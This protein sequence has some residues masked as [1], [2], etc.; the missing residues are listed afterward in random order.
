MSASQGPWLNRFV[1]HD[2]MT[3][4]GPAAAKFYSELLGWTIVERP[5]GPFIYRMIMAGPGPIGGIVEEKEIPHA[6]WMPYISVADVDA[7]ASKGASLGGS[8]CVPPSDI[9]QTGRFAVVGDPQGAYFSLYKGLPGSEGFDPDLPVVGRVCWNE[10]LTTDDAQALQY[11]S[12]MFGWTDQ[13]K[14]IGPMGTYHCVMVGETQAGGL[15]KNP[16]PGAPAFWV[17]YF[18]VEDL[19]AS[20][21]KAASLGAQ[22]CMPPT[23][24]PEVGQF[25]YLTDP[26][27]ALF[28][29]FQTLK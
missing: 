9:P 11:Y 17:A 19:A 3:K 10:L 5:M 12:A 8:T 6:H 14:D 18:L 16:M 26:T 20:T 22:I 13:P 27:G 21:A 15:M 24:I 23:P 4:D 2:L 29:L 28:A 25:S 1:W 7:A